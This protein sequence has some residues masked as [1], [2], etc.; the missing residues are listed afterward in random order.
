MLCVQV[1]LSNEVLGEWSRTLLSAKI[2]PIFTSVKQNKISKDP[3]GSL[4]LKHYVIQNYPI[5]IPFIFLE[6]RKLSDDS[7]LS[8]C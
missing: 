7:N 2:V 1:T 3:N 5:Y 6:F 8:L 4:C